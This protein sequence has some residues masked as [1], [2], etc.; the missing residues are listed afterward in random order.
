MLHRK[1][2]NYSASCRVTINHKRCRVAI[3]LKVVVEL[4][5]EWKG[6]GLKYSLLVEGVLHLL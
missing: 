2:H 5:K 4:D 3:H 6:D 1:H